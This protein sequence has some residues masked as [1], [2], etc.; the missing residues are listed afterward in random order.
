MF[1]FLV[2]DAYL[3]VYRYGESP[4]MIRDLLVTR[5][6]DC[7]IFTGTQRLIGPLQQLMLQRHTALDASS[8]SKLLHYLRILGL[9]EDHDMLLLLQERA[10]QTPRHW[11]AAGRSTAEGRAA[12]VRTLPLTVYGHA[13]TSA[14]PGAAPTATELT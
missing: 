10:E 12:C 13:A 2:I 7:R 8:A 14:V 5:C 1:R 4:W 11:A 9:P 3:R 6:C